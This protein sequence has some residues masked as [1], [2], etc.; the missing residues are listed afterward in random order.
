[1]RFLSAKPIGPVLSKL[2][3]RHRHQRLAAELYVKLVEQARSPA[4]YTVCGV[5]DT[6]DG[7]FEALALHAFLVF[8]RLKREDQPARDLAQALFDHMFADMDLSLR[9][10]G[11]TDFSIGKKVKAMGRGFYGRIVAYDHALEAEDPL[12]LESALRRNLYGTAEPEAGQ[13]RAMAGYLRREVAGLAVQP[14][15]AFLAVSPR[16]GAAPQTVEAL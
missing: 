5:P 14:V 4:F 1:L 15:D 8:H 10:I 2:L 12:E 11:V 9:E 6:L 3:T 13:V 16:F 7:R